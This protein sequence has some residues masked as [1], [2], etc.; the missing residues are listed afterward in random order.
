MPKSHYV[1]AEA[2]AGDSWFHSLQFK[3]G[4]ALALIL[5]VTAGAAWWASFALV[6]S[7]L[8]NKASDDQQQTSQRLAAELRTTLADAETLSTSLAHLAAMPE[9]RLDI[10][11]N[12]GPALLGNRALA[13][14][15]R[16]L[17]IWPEPG[18]LAGAG[19]Y[20]SLFWLRDTQDRFVIR[21]DYN[22]PRATPYFHE[23]WYTPARYL[24]EGGVYWTPLWRET[25]SQQAVITAVVPIRI[26]GQ[27]AGVATVSLD[28]DALQKRFS[29]LAQEAAGYSLLVDGELR[30]LGL[31]GTTTDISVTAGETLADLAKQHP[32]FAP[33]SIA[34]Y[35]ALDAARSRALQ[36]S[37]YDA[38]QVSALKDA[39]R[40]LSRQEAENALLGIWAETNPAAPAPAGVE[41][42]DD[43]LLHQASTVGFW[44]L[45]HPPWT[46]I[47]VTAGQ[48]AQR[49]VQPLVRQSMLLSFGCAAVL[50]LSVF[51]ALRWLV[52][53]R[54]QQMNRQL[55]RAQTPEDSLH[56]LLDASSR[57]E[58][59]MIA[60]WQ[61]ERVRQLREVMDRVEV[62]QSQLSNE[63]RERKGV[64]E[65][66]NRLR[67]T[68]STALQSLSE[69]VVITSEA[70]LIDDMNAAAETLTGMMFSEARGQSL[71]SVVR[72][73]RHGEADTPANPVRLA[74]E[75]GQRVEW[76]QD[77]SLDSHNGTVHPIVLNAA[78][79]RVRGQII[80]AVLVMR[81]A[82]PRSAIG[83]GEES[84]RT[85]HQRDLL[86]GLPGR[87]ALDRRLAALIDH[88]SGSHALACL[89]IDHLRRINDVG[90]LAAGDELLVRVAETLLRMSPAPHEVY[91]LAADQFAVLFGPVDPATAHQEAE[92]LREHIRNTRFEWES[93]PFGI[94][95]SMGLALTGELGLNPAEVIRRAGDACAA[96]KRG[97][98][99]NVLIYAPSM[100]RR[101]AN[102]D[103]QNWIRCIQQGL[104]DNLLHLRTQ[105][106]VPSADYAAEGHCYEVLVALED[107]EG[108]WAAPST[109]MPVAERY[110]LAGAIDRWVIRNTLE[111]LQ[112][113]PG[114]ASGLA[115]CS[116][117]LST[118]TLNAP[119]FLD[120]IAGALEPVP[121]L[122][123]K[124]CFELREQML[125]DH[126]RQ[127]ALC[128]EVLHRIGCRI[129]V[130]HYS[131]RHAAELAQLRKLP[132]DFV[133]MD[134]QA[135]R[136]LDSDP[137]EA[138]LAES[139][140]RIARHLRRRVI[141]NNLDEVRLLD[142]WRK[143]GADYFQG[144]GLAKPSLVA[145]QAPR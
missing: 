20:R 85:L 35:H 74:G 87:A 32:D 143:L 117:N 98:R 141:V 72:L 61:N 27:F 90:G 113:Q 96:A 132:I 101:E 121:H 16:H 47:R 75:R 86:T 125:A 126:H 45:R 105:W 3:L 110:Q 130:D 142:T 80:G 17:G 79:V 104:S 136:N 56:A 18:V 107:S 100:D 115:F 26:G 63:A 108:F 120:F 99:D 134:A 5:L 22:D 2:Q 36:S 94:T 124:L 111:Q 6:Q 129:S 64:Q 71:L 127:A 28:F 46:L 145:F 42:L 93:R 7:P 9:M 140:L 54:L 50:L 70:G 106:I 92:A 10:L 133:K 77:V 122:A 131:G 81:E 55:A 62:A 29:A 137:V 65:Q 40:D 82:L 66:L 24:R 57:D 123:G 53:R 118:D 60:H 4:L 91:R 49:D 144:Y 21:N 119:D 95:A 58:V 112:H 41:L 78:P 12:A 1:K 128:C 34:L 43:P 38:H 88:D 23:K 14:L 73:R 31:G 25:V 102:A 97:G 8:V 67:E 59:G 39:T 52:I 13:P 11:R 48:Q 19:E 89:D 37:R 51:L 68:T 30:L 83:G 15:V 44:P 135:F 139:V 109:F 114:L 76:V 84:L 116:I 103:E 69:A 138:M 33:A